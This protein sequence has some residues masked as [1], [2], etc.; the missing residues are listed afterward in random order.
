MNHL[1]LQENFVGFLKAINKINDAAI[2]S[3]SENS[4]SCLVGTPDNSCFVYATMPC[5]ATFS[6]FLNIPSI[7][8]LSKALEHTDGDIDFIVNVN[9]LEYKSPLVRFKYHLLENGIL[10]QPLINIKK[11]QSVEFDVSFNINAQSLSDLSKASTF[12]SDS[13]KMYLSCDGEKLR[14]ELTDRARYNIDSIEMVIGELNQPFDAV[15]INLDFFR[16]LTYSN[17]SN[18]N[19]KIN[20]KLGVVTIDIQNDGH[21]L[22]YITSAFTS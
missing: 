1:T 14:A 11:I 15:P 13:N 7:I 3:T 2:L 5:K 17:S 21:K 4:L 16:S 20:S 22:K 19:F 6:S 10:S 12:A 9:N 8:K 18:I